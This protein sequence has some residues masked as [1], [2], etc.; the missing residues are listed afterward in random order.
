MRICKVLPDIFDTHRMCVTLIL[1]TDWNIVTVKQSSKTHIYHAVVK[2]TIKCA[3]ETWCLK[4]KTVENSKFHRKGL[5]STLS[6]N[7]Q[8]GQN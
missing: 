3:A 5:L 1:F 4:A 8:E 7:F 6:S 2:S